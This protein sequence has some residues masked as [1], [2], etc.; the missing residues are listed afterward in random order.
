MTFLIELANTA[1]ALPPELKSLT[2]EQLILFAD[3]CSDYVE[4]SVGD[5]NAGVA[6][7]ARQHGDARSG[8]A[9]TLNNATP[10]PSA[11]SELMASHTT[12]SASVVDTLWAVTQPLLPAQL[13][14]GT[15][16]E[17]VNSDK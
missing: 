4:D 13:P 1:R 5:N 7:G 10:L 3:I 12:L 2:L 16:L 15:P 14:S 8:F 11:I 6:S 9:A 17:S